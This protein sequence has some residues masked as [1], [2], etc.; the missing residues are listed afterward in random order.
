MACT[1]NDR[2]NVCMVARLTSSP[3]LTLITRKG[4]YALLVTCD[5][6]KACST[7]ELS[8]ELKVTRAC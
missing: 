5:Y 4:Q 8:A 6:R 3:V 2:S 7:R 1:D